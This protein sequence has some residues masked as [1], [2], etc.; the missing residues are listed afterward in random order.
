MRIL[1]YLLM[2]IIGIV[3]GYKEISHKRLLEG[4]DKLQMVALLILLG[5]MGVR[6]GADQEVLSSIEVIGLRGLVFALV[7]IAFSVAPVY[8]YS[9]YFMKGRAGR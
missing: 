6:I 2:L 1:L 4:L 3:I 9:R 5:V 7:T 8:I